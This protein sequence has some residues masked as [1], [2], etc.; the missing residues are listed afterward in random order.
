MT[1]EEELIALREENKEL[2]EQLAQRD[3]LIE[4]QQAL[5]AGHHNADATVTIDRIPT[6]V[7]R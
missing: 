6:G 7:L 1:L 2:R 5:L 3:E 4:Q